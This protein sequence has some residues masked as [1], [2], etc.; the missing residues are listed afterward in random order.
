MQSIIG[1]FR[2]EKNI[3]G[4]KFVFQKSLKQ[5]LFIQFLFLLLCWSFAREITCI[6]PV[7]E[8]FPGESVWALRLILLV[9]FVKP[10]FR[11][12][13]AFFNICGHPKMIS[14]CSFSAQILRFL[15]VSFLI[16]IVHVE[17]WFWLFELLAWSF[18]LILVISMVHIVKYKKKHTGFLL[19]RA[20]ENDA[21]SYHFLLKGDT[22]TF[23]DYRKMLQLFLKKQK[24][25]HHTMDRVKHLFEEL[26]LFSQDQMEHKKDSFFSIV[27]TVSDKE[28]EMDLR[29]DSK[30]S[31]FDTVLSGPHIKLTPDK[32]AGAKILSLL[33]DSMYI[34]RIYGFNFVRLTINRAESHH[35]A[36]PLAPD[37]VAQ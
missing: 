33:S 23:Q 24:I 6:F 15:F 2:G 1:V 37:T 28:V 14:F 19:L 32:L 26:F 4:I 31:C 36:E 27:T 9:I 8:N 22:E 17:K 10:L 11:L 30:T 21:A 18:S 16:F 3:N 34:D 35:S 13:C 20:P 12:L 25:D 7:D 5:G 29:Y